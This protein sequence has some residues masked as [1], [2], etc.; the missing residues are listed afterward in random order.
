MNNSIRSVVSLNRRVP[1]PR[2]RKPLAITYVLKA[3]VC[4][5]PALAFAQ[6]ATTMTPANV[7]KLPFSLGLQLG[8]TLYL[9]GHLGVDPAIGKAPA[10]PEVEA[11]QVLESVAQTLKQ[12]HL[13][14]DDLVYVEIYCTDLSMYG[15]FNKIYRSYFRPVLS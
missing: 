10:D 1:K 14:M 11:R 2:G 12:A 3:L 6:Q 9:S 8:E 15:A 4:V 5:L 13:S 7:A